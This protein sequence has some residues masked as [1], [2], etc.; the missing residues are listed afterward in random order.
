MTL[1]VP[2]D[3]EVMD[4]SSP[5]KSLPFRVDGDMF[6]AAPDVAAELAIEFM[7]LSAKLDDEETA[8]VQDQ[9]AVLHAMFK[10]V[11]FPDSADRFIARLRDTTKPIGY[12]KVNRIVKWLFE[13]YGLRP[14]EP[15]E[16]S[17]T[18]SESQVAGKSL[19]ASTSDAA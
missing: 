16:S 18:G 15:A 1:S 8:S 10:M 6:E 4:F 11:L 7:D 12:A 14:T 13:A 9:I 3:D 5:R 19:T 2:L 17:S